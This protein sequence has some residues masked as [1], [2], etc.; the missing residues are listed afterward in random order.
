M[1]AIEKVV[2]CLGKEASVTEADRGFIAPVR[3][4][5][6][7]VYETIERERTSKISHQRGMEV[8]QG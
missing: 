2:R 4:G 8:N 7:E 1:E 3:E 6:R 5:S